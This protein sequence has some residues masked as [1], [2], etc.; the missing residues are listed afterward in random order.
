M[1]LSLPACWYGRPALEAAAAA[2]AGRARCVLRRAGPV[3]RVTV[4]PGALAGEFLD[5]ALN[6]ELRALVVA[7]A[8]PTT[9]PVLARVFSAGFTAVPKDPLEEMEPQVAEARAEET[10][11]LLA[12]AR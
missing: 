3:H 11:A 4:R 1:T 7:D 12:R 5:E 6:A 10:A 8:R 2:L 9:G